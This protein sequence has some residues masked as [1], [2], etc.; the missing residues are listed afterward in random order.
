MNLEGI[1]PYAQLAAQAPGSANAVS[2]FLVRLQ[3]V[4]DVDVCR[5]LAVRFALQPLV[6]AS[7]WGRVSA[8]AQERGVKGGEGAAAD[9]VDGG[10]VLM[11]AHGLYMLGIDDAAR[12]AVDMVLGAE[13]DNVGAMEL[14]AA[15]LPEASEQR[16]V[17][18]RILEVEPGNRRAVESLILLGRPQ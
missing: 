1:L 6:A 16:R 5:E 11:A 2:N 9:G 10:M 17:F 8:L 14:L 4:A 7:A 13:P 18:E 3:L 15:L 12:A